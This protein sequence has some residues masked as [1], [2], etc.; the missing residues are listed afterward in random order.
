[1]KKECVMTFVFVFAIAALAVMLVR[2]VEKGRVE[3]LRAVVRMDLF[4]I[5]SVFIEDGLVG[6]EDAAIEEL[7]LMENSGDQNYR[8]YY[9]IL[10]NDC[11]VLLLEARG[12]IDYDADVDI[13]CARV[14]LTQS[15]EVVFM[16]VIDD[17]Q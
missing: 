12:N 17:L 4:S 7:G 1:M 2:L 8:Y 11:D 3:E 13:I 14:D 10:G 5:A 16:Q 15:R 9:S 6:D